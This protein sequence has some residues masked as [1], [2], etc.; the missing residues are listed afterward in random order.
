MRL[1]TLMKRRAVLFDTLMAL[2]QS[3]SQCSS[4]PRQASTRSDGLR[5]VDTRAAL[6]VYCASST[7]R[8]GVGMSFTYR[9][10]STGETSQPW[11][12]PAR[13]PRRVDVA[14]WK[15]VWNVLSQ[16]MKI[17]FAPRKTRSCRSLCLNK[18][19]DHTTSSGN[20]AKCRL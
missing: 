7:W 9:L 1:A 18:D 20:V 14:D 12:A 10:D 17:C 15:D 6:S 2:L 11:T 5:D 16:D 3:R 19:S 4:L 13:M 8:E